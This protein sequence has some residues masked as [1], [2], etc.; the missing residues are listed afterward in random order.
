MSSA[1]MAQHPPLPLDDLA[2]SLSFDDEEEALEFSRNRGI[3]EQWTTEDSGKKKLAVRIDNKTE[4][5]T[6]ASDALRKGAL[7]RH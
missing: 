3:G 4:R 2:K 7:G 5:S 6:G 1:Y